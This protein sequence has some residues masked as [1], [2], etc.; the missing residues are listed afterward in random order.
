MTKTNPF[1]KLLNPPIHEVICEFAFDSIPGVTTPLLGIYWGSRR[2]AFPQAST[3]P[4]VG[5]NAEEGVW[6]TILQ[7]VLLTDADGSHF[8]QLQHDRFYANWSA[9]GSEYPRFSSRDGHHGLLHFA[10]S[11]FHQFSN[12]LKNE[13]DVCPKVTDIGLTKI[14]ILK[15]GTFW[16]NLSDLATVLPIVT[17]ISALEM[18][19]ESNDIAINFQFGERKNDAPLWVR[20]AT[21]YSDSEE[22]A[23]RL[24]ARIQCPV[25]ENDDIEVRF[26]T[27]NARL[28]Q[29]F[30]SLISTQGLA[31]FA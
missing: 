31:R 3:R 18:L 9:V 1:P 23:I 26:D 6:D 14:D 30:F 5:I 22:K 17:P 7:R 11:E 24:E 2:D 21:G 15:Q 19:E 16:E 29:I 10:M 25:Q 12:F 20:I 28:N 4:V 27:I 13:L 8:V